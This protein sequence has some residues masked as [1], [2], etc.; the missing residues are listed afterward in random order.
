[1]S[2]TLVIL[3]TY[4]EEANI[5]P[6]LEGLWQSHKDLHVLVVDDGSED[7]T[8]ARVKQHQAHPLGKERLFLL[9]RRG[10]KGIGNALWEGICYALEHQYAYVV[11]MDADLSHNPQ[12]VPKLLS[13]CKEGFDVVIGSRYIQGVSVVNWPIG[14]I[15]LS[16]VASAYVRLITGMPIR[17]TTAG[18][19]C[20]RAEVLAYIHAREVPFSGYAFQIAT[21]FLA[22]KGHAR[23][24][25][26]SILFR[27]RNQGVSKMS[28]RTFRQAF[29]D[30]GVLM[31]W[32][33]FRKFPPLP[34]L[35]S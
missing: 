14:R 7:G 31:L 28:M 27:E 17:D 20:F 5:S 12:D 35:L 19:V 3:P 6:M 21:K 15:I 29:L 16:Y 30:V 34:H 10:K 24:K 18:F 1:M 32:S 33:I 25:E 22:W 13:T 11:Q 2:K 26:M 9:Q 8:V 23:I 4:C